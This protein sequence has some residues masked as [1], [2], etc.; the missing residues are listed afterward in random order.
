VTGDAVAAVVA[1]ETRRRLGVVGRFVAAVVIGGIV[2]AIIFLIMVQGSFRKGH[3]GLD[4]NH[5][6]GTMVEGSAEEAR[7]T[8]EALGV[9]GDTVGQT[10]LY[11]TCLAAIALMVVHGL[12]IVRLV[13]RPWYVQALPL[14]VLTFL[15]IGLVYCPLADS[16]LDT[17]TGLFGVDAG[18]RT[19]LVLGLSSLGFAAVAARCFSLVNDARWWAPKHE[20]LETALEAVPDVEPGTASLELAEDG[21][22]QRRVGT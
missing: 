21:P 18:G 16:R 22:E 9:I 12:V 13:R 1:P 10:G 7:S 2:G 11:V 5:V 17:P 20:G 19:P 14:A 15:V 6:L 3:T 8:D 4:F